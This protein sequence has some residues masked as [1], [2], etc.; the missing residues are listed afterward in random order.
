MGQWFSLG[1]G[2]P[3]L[4]ASEGHRTDYAIILKR[5]Q[6]QIRSATVE[7]CSFSKL[8][9]DRLKRVAPKLEILGLLT[10][11]LLR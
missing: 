10:L 1:T 9:Y 3:L 4:A 5:P 8:K 2:H 6:S 7:G 11:T